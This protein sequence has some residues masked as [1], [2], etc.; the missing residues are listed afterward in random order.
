MSNGLRARPDAVDRVEPGV[1]TSSYDET[2]VM[3]L[4]LESLYTEVSVA[5]GEVV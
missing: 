3:L 5:R 4:R 2:V 1:G